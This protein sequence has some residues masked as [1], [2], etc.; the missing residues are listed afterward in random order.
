MTKSSNSS[1]MNRTLAALA[2]VGLMATVGTAQASYMVSVDQQS[3]PS[4]GTYSGAAFDAESDFQGR[5]DSSTTEDFEGFDHNDKSPNTAVGDFKRGPDA[6]DGSGNNCTDQCEEPAV[7]K[8][9][10]DPS[11]SGRYDTTG[12]NSNTYLDSNDVTQ[13]EWDLSGAALD[14]MTNA[15]GFYLMDPSDVGAEFEISTK[16]GNTELFSIESSQDNGELFYVSVISTDGPI[17]DASLFLE[18]AD[19]T[20]ADGFGIDDATVGVP[21]PGMLALLGSS[22]LALGVFGRGRRLRV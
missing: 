5:L 13:V 9:D 21:A 7:F 20:Q 19:N 3:K 10:Q 1:P 8:E 18:N 15:V 22:L 12:P 4:S 6:V 16:D 2:T 14:P 17:A 11:D